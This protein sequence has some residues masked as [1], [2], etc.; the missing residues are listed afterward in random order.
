MEVSS[1]NLQVSRISG[2][3]PIGFWGCARGK[4]RLGPWSR[5]LISIHFLFRIY[6]RL[7]LPECKYNRSGMSL[8]AM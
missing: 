1:N 2:L 6:S 5:R 7:L 8:G 4:A 3:H